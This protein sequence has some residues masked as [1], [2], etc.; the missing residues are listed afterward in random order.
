M[1]SRSPTQQYPKTTTIS[2]RLRYRAD[3][4]FSVQPPEIPRLRNVRPRRAATLP[5]P[6]YKPLDSH[7]QGSDQLLEGLRHEDLAS[8]LQISCTLK[9]AEIDAQA[10]P[11][12]SLGQTLDLRPYNSPPGSAIVTNQ[13]RSLSDLA[14][15]HYLVSD[16]PPSPLPSVSGSLEFDLSSSYTNHQQSH[17]SYIDPQDMR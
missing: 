17:N 6:H 1:T 12:D 8:N 5:E 2:R 9:P 3:Q 15:S 14:Q 4:G 16:F 11:V 13:T 7:R 10:Q